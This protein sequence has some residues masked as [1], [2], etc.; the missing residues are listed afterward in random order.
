MGATTD[1]SVGY[2]AWLLWGGDE[3]KIWAD[4]N[5]ASLDDDD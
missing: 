4:R 1:P 3:G 2:I 5:A